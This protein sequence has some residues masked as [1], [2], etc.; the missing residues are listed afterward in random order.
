M[1]ELVDGLDLSATLTLYEGDERGCPP[2]HPV[3]LTKVL[4]YACCAGVFS[5]RRIERRL[6]E[7]VAFRVPARTREARRVL[8]ARAKEAAEARRVSLPDAA[9]PDEKAQ[10]NLTGP[11]S[12]I[13]GVQIHESAWH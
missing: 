4:L 5:S 8:E 13:R 2:Y 10:Y 1:S 3:M 7:D 9:K 6:L 11:E 12:Q